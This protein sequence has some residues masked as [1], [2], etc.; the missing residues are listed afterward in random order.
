MRSG[1]EGLRRRPVAGWGIRFLVHD[2]VL[3]AMAARNARTARRIA[4]AALALA[5]QGVFYWL[6]LHEAV[7]PTVLRSSKPLQ[8]IIFETARRLYPATLPRK[9]RR[10]LSSRRAVRRDEVH[11]ALLPIAAKPIAAQPI[12]VEPI[13]VRPIGLPP[14]ANAAAHPP[15]DWQHEIQREARLQD[16]QAPAGQIRFGFPE[17]PA[18]A[19]SAPE[20]GWD[21]AHT[22][23]LQPLSGGGMLIN[24]N[25]HCALVIYGLMFVPGC[26][27][28]RIP[29]NGRLFDHLHD[30]RD[31][32]P[33]ALP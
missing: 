9:R 4:S 33:G 16:A 17:A 2:T 7:E 15:P 32:G 27:I 11:P 24:L 28:G 31:D 10:P 18:S 22:H 14:A 21:Y 6:M 5:L 29:A 20:F 3:L 8:V 1:E 26:R 19:P 23:R 13:S 25:D 30:R 12:T